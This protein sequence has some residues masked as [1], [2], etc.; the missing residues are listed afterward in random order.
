MSMSVPVESPRGILCGDR[1][2][3]MF[4]VMLADIPGALL[5]A[6]TVFYSYGLNV[7]SIYTTE[8]SYG[9]RQEVEVNFVVDFTGKRVSPEQVAKSLNLETVVKQVVFYGKQLPNMIVD[10][11]HFPLI[12]MGERAI[13]FR[14][15]TY[16]GLILGLRKQ[17]GA[18]GEALLYHIGLNNGKGTWAALKNLIGGKVELLP[19][20]LKY[21]MF[22]GGCQRC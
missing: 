9:D 17:L 13:I 15:T 5:K 7:V 22:A 21:W 19:Q 8:S 3:Y 10:E 18:A 12:V 2:L 6:A 14:E 1:E 11:K 16:K 4:H 20:Y